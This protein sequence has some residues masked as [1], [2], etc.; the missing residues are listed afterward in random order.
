MEVPKNKRFYFEASSSSLLAG[1]EVKG[2]TLARAHV[3]L[4]RMSWGTLGT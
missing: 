2:G 1:L 4:L 3:M